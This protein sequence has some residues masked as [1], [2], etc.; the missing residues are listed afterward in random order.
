[1]VAVLKCGSRQKKKLATFLKFS[2]RGEFVPFHLIGMT[3]QTDINKTIIDC[4][5]AD[6]LRAFCG[7]CK[8]PI[9]ADELKK[10]EC[11]KCGKI[12]QDKILIKS[13]DNI[14]YS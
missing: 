12:E 10:M 3:T 13:A 8:L 5:I 11:S 7:E 9:S 14:I 4:V 6:K 2:C 1:M